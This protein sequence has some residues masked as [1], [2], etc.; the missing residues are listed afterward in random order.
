[1]TERRPV[2][3]AAEIIAIQIIKN[4]VIIVR[5]NNEMKSAPNIEGQREK[6]SNTDEER[7]VCDAGTAKRD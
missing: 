1:M 6:R 3:S 5:T 2:L 4:M 7:T